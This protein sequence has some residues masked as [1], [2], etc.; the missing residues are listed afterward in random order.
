MIKYWTFALLG[1]F[2]FIKANAL[3]TLSLPN[4]LISFDSTAGIK[5]LQQSQHKTAFWKLMP[6]FTTERGLTFCG[7]ASA[8]M[9]LNAL[10]IEPPLTPEHAPYRIFNQT[11]FFNA[12]TIKIT[13]P[14]RVGYHGASLIEIALALK[15]FSINVN[16][17]Y[18]RKI[19]EEMFRQRAIEAVS[20]THKFILVNFCRKYIN[21]KGCGHFSPL[22]AYNKKADRF[23]LLDV[24]RYKYPSVWVKTSDLYRAIR[25]GI[26]NGTGKSRGFIIASINKH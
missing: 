12:K 6:Y 11:N 16:V 7:I 14:S 17:M 1:L 23:L 8:V 20:S 25:K 15:T 26:D 2:I 24:A 21:E 4:N 3:P 9:I 5:L 22:A 10:N 13:T 18:G 19:S